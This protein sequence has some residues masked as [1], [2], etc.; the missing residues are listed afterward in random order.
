MKVSLQHIPR[1]IQKG[2]T[3]ESPSGILCEIVK[4]DS[5]TRL[6]HYH[7]ATSPPNA[8]IKVK[9]T[10]FLRVW[11][12]VQVPP[13]TIIVELTVEEALELCRDEGDN[14]QSRL[15]RQQLRH[16]VAKVPKE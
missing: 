5:G 10:L 4:F 15:F 1:G 8:V 12:K 11:K 6:V 13:P 2:S 9:E 3:Y 16:E 14:D 7:L